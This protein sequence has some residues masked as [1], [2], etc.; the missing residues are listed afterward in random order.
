MQPRRPAFARAEALKRRSAEAPKRQS[1]EAP[2]RQS[3]KSPVQALE[4]FASPVGG[5][6]LGVHIKFRLYAPRQS[7]VGQLLDLP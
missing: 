2:K 5:G 3:A 7:F 1:A 6:F 4:A